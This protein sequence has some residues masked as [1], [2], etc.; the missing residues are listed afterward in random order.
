MQRQSDR[1]PE[2]HLA[3]PGGSSR[4][5]PLDQETGEDGGETGDV[6]HDLV[7][8]PAEARIEPEQERHRERRRPAQARPHPA[9]EERGG[10]CAEQAHVEVQGAEI[11]AEERDDGRQQQRESR[12]PG[13]E[14][15]PEIGVTLAGEQRSGSAD[16]DRRVPH[17]L[18]PGVHHEAQADPHHQQ[19]QQEGQL[20]RGC[21]E[22]CLARRER[23]DWHASLRPAHGLVNIAAVL[24]ARLQTR[25]PCGSETTGEG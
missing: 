8:E 15:D 13:D 4:R 11:R 14:R 18:V 20:F 1:E 6:R 23:V 17:R 9:V 25:P 5:P 16:I 19:E 3:A 10:D 22:G 2:H 21:A 12:R 24:A 7:R